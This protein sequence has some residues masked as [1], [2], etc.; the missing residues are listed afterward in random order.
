MLRRVG[1][2]VLAFVLGTSLDVSIAG[3][4]PPRRTQAAPRPEIYESAALDDNGNIR[5]TTMDHRTILVRKDGV[6]DNIGQQTG[7]TEPILSPNHTAVGAQ[8]EYP[9]CCTSYDIPLELV[10]YAQ[11]RLHRFRG[12]NIPIFK[13]HFA[14]DGQR[15]AYSQS[16][17]HFSCST[18]Y[19]L[20]TIES[21]HL[22]DSVDVPEPC[23]QIQHPKAVKVP[24][25]VT[26]LNKASPR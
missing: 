8:A 26:T 18:H 6:L 23:S 14:D 19:E 3:Q 20:R 4:A 13:W 22:I 16:S 1:P 2:L 25:W 5:I 17:V 21:E 24:K 11:G 12:I 15:I 10:V 7:F 9:N